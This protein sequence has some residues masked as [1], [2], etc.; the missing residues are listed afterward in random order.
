[1]LVGIRRHC[2]AVAV[3]TAD[4]LVTPCFASDPLGTA[5]PIRSFGSGSCNVS[6]AARMRGECDPPAIASTLPP[7]RRSQER[8]ERARL[9][10][11]VLRVDQAVNELDTAIAEDPLNGSA[12]VLRA[13]LKMPGRLDE[14]ERDVNRALQIDPANSNALATRAFIVPG[15]KNSLGLRDATRALDIDPKNADALWIRS[16]IFVRMG[17]LDA[18][19]R[20]LDSALELEP[21]EPRTLLSRAEIRMRVGKTEDAGR[22]ATAVLAL[23]RFDK[24]ALQIRAVVHAR[25]GDYAGALDD[26]NVV[27][28]KPA[29]RSGVAPIR[30]DLVNLYVQRALALA[31]TGK[32]VEA[33]Q[34]LDAIVTVGGVR[35]ILQ[36]QLYLRSHGFPDV[37]LDGKRSDQLDEAL[38]ACFI[39]DACGRGITIRG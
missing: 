7:G 27:L 35:A 23:R 16:T 3:L 15:E 25:S 36:M 2:V 22:D 13:R 20:D 9:L 33:K 38:Q 18:A 1:M 4:L 29:D 5:G 28:G 34:D 19:E 39:N 26:L 32:P 37:N 10:I 12:L 6:Y 14:A 11:S 17:R 24:G 31:R 8:V 30:P 21:D